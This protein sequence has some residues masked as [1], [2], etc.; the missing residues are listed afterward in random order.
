[1]KKHLLVLLT[2]LLLGLPGVANASLIK[3]DTVIYDDVNE[4]YWIRDLSL[5]VNQTYDQQLI[6][7]GGL[8][9]NNNYKSPDWGDWHMADLSE[10][11]LLHTYRAD[12]F[13]YQNRFTPT[14]APW[15][16][17]PPDQYGFQYRW[18]GYI[19]ATSSG[20]R[21][22]GSSIFWDIDSP[23]DPQV[24][25]YI[26]PNS[27]DDQ[28]GAWVVAEA[29]PSQTPVPATM[30]LFGVGLLGISGCCRKNT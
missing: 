15:V 14:S 9:D 3:Y 7:I 18:Q 2:T 12:E 20:R 21:L 26:A 6:T 24:Y 29:T 13:R 1:M 4:L 27:Y 11:Q 25:H 23:F 28:I 22:I 5:F 30:I 19:D 17:S 10:M 8:N 16:V